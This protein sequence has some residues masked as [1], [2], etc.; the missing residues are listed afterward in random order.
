MLKEIIHNTA[1]KEGFRVEK[2]PSVY[3]KYFNVLDELESD[4]CVD[5]RLP[6]KAII[7]KIVQKYQI[8]KY[9]GRQFPGGTFGVVDATRKIL[10][11]EEEAGLEFV[12]NTYKLNGLRMGD[13]IDNL[14]ENHKEIGSEAKLKE[15]VDGCGKE[16]V[17]NGS[18]VAVYNDLGLTPESTSK[19]INWIKENDGDI[20]IL[21]GPHNETLAVANLIESE[22]ADVEKAAGEGKS[23]F[24]MDIKEAYKIGGY[25]FETALSQG[26]HMK[27]GSKEEFQIAFTR[28]MVTDYLQTLAALGYQNEKE[29]KVVFL[30]D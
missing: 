28:L 5:G 8:E 22:T 13:H 17:T 2:L 4:R 23:F 26:I 7:Q 12:K 30:N 16:N 29:Q 3:L 25:I 9:R 6:I 21:G 18:K 19:R 27:Q 20:Y 14:D 11:L 1:K 24:N 10:G 15:K